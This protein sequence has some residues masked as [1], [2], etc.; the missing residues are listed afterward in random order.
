MRGVRS[1]HVKPRWAWLYAVLTVLI[2]LLG[3]IEVGVPEGPIRRALEI[4][5]T[6][7]IFGVMALWVARNRV[8]LVLESEPEPEWESVRPAGAPGERE[9]RATPARHRYTSGAVE[10]YL[11]AVGN[12]R[13]HAGPRR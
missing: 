10:E 2:T 6:L 12:G 13:A 7:G 1:R 9:L 5:V 3:V 11:T 4:F 8:Q